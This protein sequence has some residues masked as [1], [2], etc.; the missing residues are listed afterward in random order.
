[1]QRMNRPNMKRLG[2]FI[3]QVDTRNRDLA[4]DN[5]LGLSISKQFIPSIANIIG[6]D[7]ANYKI[8]QP[9]QF[10][11]VPVTSR[12]GD[13]ITVALYD[14]DKPCIISQAYIVFEVADKDKLLPEYLMMWFRRP[15]F[16]RYARFKS[17]GSAREVFEWDEMCEV[18]LPLP[19][20]EEQRKI[21]AEY[22]AVERR[23]E[24]N[25]RLIATLESAAQTIY[26]QMFVDNIDPEN[27]P[28]GWRRGTIGDICVCNEESYSNKDHWDWIKYL[29]SSSVT[30][31]SFDDYQ[32]LCVD[33]D[34]IPSRA[35]RKVRDNDFIISTVRPNLCHFGLIRGDLRNVL[36]STAFAVIHSK[37]EQIS[38]ELIYLWVT[39]SNTIEK[40]NHVAEMSKATYPSIVPDDILNIEISFPHLDSVEL[41]DFTRNIVTLFDAIHT[42]RKEISILEEFHP[43]LQSKLSNL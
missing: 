28:Q 40:L 32:I 10:G 5:L 39:D 6:T 9:R 15:E 33:K 18:M 17:H 12:N 25:R 35:K 21:V 1:M 16:D 29:D 43:I 2:D 26:R 41:K 42:Y 20:I 13:K 37:Y 4:V 27:L 8:V 34:E 14:G 11:Y 38:N 24:N 31:N 36:V 7:M 3:R 23:I 30:S 22:Q 19:S